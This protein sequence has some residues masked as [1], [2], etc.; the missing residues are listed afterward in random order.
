MAGVDAVLLIIGEGPLLAR[1]QETARA[2]GVADRVQFLGRV[3]RIVEYYRACDM[4]VLPSTERAE[5]FGLVQ[6]EAMACGKPVVNTWVPSGVPVVSLN[7]VTGL[8][9]APKDASALADAM[10]LLL[11]DSEL[12]LRY[13]MAARRRVEKEF[14]VDGMIA[15]TLDLYLSPP[16]TVLDEF[17]RTMTLHP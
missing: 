13:G 1:L 16:N 10:R 5:A 2:A 3:D 11:E 6:L 15:R 4:F 17:R 9:V 8:T 12:R 7:G 14:T